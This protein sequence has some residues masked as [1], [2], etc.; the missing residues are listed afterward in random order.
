MTD[1]KQIRLSDLEAQIRAE[2]ADN[3]DEEAGGTDFDPHDWL[4]EL[5]DGYVPIYNYDLLMLAADELWLAVDVPEIYAFGGEHSA[6]N[7]IAGNVFE[8][9]RGEAYAEFEKLKDE[10]DNE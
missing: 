6:V 5:A 2:V 8:H 10:A 7:A 1:D 9:L 3:F 4:T